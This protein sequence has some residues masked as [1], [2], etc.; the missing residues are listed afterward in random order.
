MNEPSTKIALADNTFF[1]KE[2][3]KEPAKYRQNFEIEPFN[4]LADLNWDNEHTEI[5]AVADQQCHVFVRGDNLNKTYSN[6]WQIGKT[7]LMKG[8]HRPSSRL[9]MLECW[10]LIPFVDIHGTLLSADV[11]CQKVIG[12]IIPGPTFWYRCHNKDA[13]ISDH[14]SSC[15]ELLGK[16][17]QS[18]HVD[19]LILTEPQSP[20][21][22]EGW[23]SC[24][25]DLS[26]SHFN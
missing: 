1:Y 9:K 7:T 26:R 20:E 17:A 15:L 11:F 18:N 21:S 6:V 5:F 23:V 16:A 8:E 2:L 22:L 4:S 3:P 24:A 10:K 25:V 12:S 14:F 13:C 19:W